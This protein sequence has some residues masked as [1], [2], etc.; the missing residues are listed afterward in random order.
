MGGEGGGMIKIRPNEIAGYWQV[1]AKF[2]QNTQAMNEC[3][4]TCLTLTWCGPHPE[5]ACHHF[6]WYPDPDMGEVLLY[7]RGEINCPHYGCDH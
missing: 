3:R 7:K 2:R 1:N 6:D 4:S 5:K